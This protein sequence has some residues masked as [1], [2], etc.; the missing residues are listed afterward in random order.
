MFKTVLGPM[1]A[2]SVT[3]H[4][5]AFP[6]VLSQLPGVKGIFPS[7]TVCFEM[8][9]GLQ[10]WFGSP[11]S[12]YLDPPCT[13]TQ[14]HP[15]A[16]PARLGDVITG[17]GY[18]YLCVVLCICVCDHQKFSDKIGMKPE[19]DLLL[20]LWS[21][22]DF[23]SAQCVRCQDGIPTISWT[24]R[25][26]CLG[27]VSEGRMEG[28]LQQP[29]LRG[30]GKGRGSLGREGRVP[31]YKWV[32]REAAGFPSRKQPAVGHCCVPPLIPFCPKSPV[33]KTGLVDYNKN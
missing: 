7:Q 31:L 16:E 27:G 20:L 12:Q 17:L 8:I 6:I 13:M 26:L 2:R 14:S 21:Q 3:S 15:Y 23:P 5:K 24:A 10:P 19:V 29:N 30:T 11:V 32:S 22:Q 25:V 9:S 33:S 28:I 4:N 1:N 18:M